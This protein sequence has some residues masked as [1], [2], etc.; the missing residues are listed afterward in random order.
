MLGRTTEGQA[1]QPDVVGIFPGSEA[2]PTDNFDFIRGVGGE[3]PL[4]VENADPVLSLAT[5]Q[6]AVSVDAGS[7]KSSAC[8]RIQYRV[9]RTFSELNVGVTGANFHGERH[10]VLPA[11]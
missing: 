7:A 9:D 10:L 3:E 4:A 1:L 8:V 11:H 6:I 2:Y 5:S